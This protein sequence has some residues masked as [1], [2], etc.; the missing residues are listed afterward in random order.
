MKLKHWQG[1]GSVTAVRV[2]DKSCDLHVRISGNHEW[3]LVPC[4]EDIGYD[5]IM[6]R[7]NKAA[8]AT[9]YEYERKGGK[10]TMLPER[11]DDKAKEWVTDYIFKREEF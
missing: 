8:P 2:K 3:G 11:W 6:K 5:W 10:L 4:M 9:Y 1:Y 7:F